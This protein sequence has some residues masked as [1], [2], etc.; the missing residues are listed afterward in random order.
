MNAAMIIDWKKRLAA[1]GSALLLA[2]SLTACDLGKKDPASNASTQTTEGAGTTASTA[3]TAAP[4]TGTTAPTRDETLPSVAWVTA[5]SMHVRSGPGFVPRRGGRA[6]HRLVYRLGGSEFRLIFSERFDQRMDLM[7]KKSDEQNQSDQKSQQA[8]DRQVLSS[9][10]RPSA[11]PPAP[12]GFQTFSHSQHPP[13]PLVLLF[14]PSYARGR[15]G[16]RGFL[17][18]SRFS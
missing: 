14:N 10:R 17:K 9:A 15:A 13:Y 3:S 2:C 12:V 4:T 1:G 11:R 18:R 5:D 7:V 6:G 8:P 16:V